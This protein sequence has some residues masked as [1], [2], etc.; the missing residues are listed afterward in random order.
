MANETPLDQFKAV[1]SGTARAIAEEPEVE[2]AFTADAPSQSGKHI[3]VPMPARALPAEQVAEARGFAD[4]F[5]LRLKHHDSAMHLR[6]APAEAV[7]RAVFDAVEGAR[8]EALGSRGYAG[9]ADNLGHALDV[10]LRADPITRARTREEVPLSTALSLMVR[11]ALTGKQA[12]AAA[13]PG[14][15]LVREWIE[16]R[17]DLS[18]LALA[19]DDQRAFQ[20]LAMKMLAELELIEG[21]VKPEEADD[22][23]SEDEGTDDQQQDE[24]EDSE[25]EDAGQ[26]EGQ[27]DAR[28]EQQQSDS[29]DSEGEEFGEDSMDDLDGEAGEDGDDGTQPVRPNRPSGE[30][31][32]QFDYKPWTT[33]FDEVIAATDLCDADELARLRGYLDQQ[34]A[35]L[36]SAVSK[37]ANR[38]QRRLMAQQS[39]SWD[40]DQDEGMLDAAR[41][42]RVVVNPTQSLSYKIER[43]TDFRDTVVTLLIDNSG[44]MRGRPI[45]IAA[46]SAD[47][48]A[49]TLERC[50]VKTE[51]LGF[52]TRAWKGGQSRETWLAAGRPPQPGRLNDIRH[53]V[54]KKADE[55][56]RR[57][58][59]NLGLMMREGLLKENI[60]GEALLWAHNRLIARPE[61]RRI[62]MVISD[63]APVDDSTLSVNSGSYLE[64]HLRQVIG[65]IEGKSPVELVAIGIGH[66]VTRYY[67]RAVTIMDAEQLGGTIIEQLAALFD[68]P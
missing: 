63:G 5:A 16:Q 33:Q 7:A 62:L 10:R 40:F 8:V 39:R 46:I 48:L 24:G 68:T 53:I 6:H 43:E 60:D 27:V 61:D 41:L 44:S 56:W 25:D 42:A 52:T 9:I 26:G 2:L 59:N 29:D 67:A 12:P 49:R 47:I 36:Q 22:G 38:L 11:E 14:L 54:Y 55:P 3:K 37:L 23:G 65:W 18:S 1:L 15:A 13:V 58:R 19:L 17:T 34:L 31:M 64:R 57:A 45:G 4:G 66:D 35:H 21:E 32:P 28:G 50:G 30:Y 51:I 20:S